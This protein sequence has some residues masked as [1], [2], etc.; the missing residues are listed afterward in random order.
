MLTYFSLEYSFNFSGFC[1]DCLT[2]EPAGEMSISC[3]YLLMVGSFLSC[4]EFRALFDMGGFSPTFT[5]NDLLTLGMIT[6]Q[7]QEKRS[8]Q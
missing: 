8:Q 1:Q 2:T 5:E 3:A 7:F 6:D 4:M